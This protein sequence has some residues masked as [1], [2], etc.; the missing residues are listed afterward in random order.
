MCGNATLAT[1]VSNTSMNV[2]IVTTMA[3]TQGLCGG[4]QIAS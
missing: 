2:A 4:F 1:L 3:M